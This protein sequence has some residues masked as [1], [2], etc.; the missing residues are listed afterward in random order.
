MPLYFYLVTIAASL[1]GLTIAYYIDA[2][3]R[4]G[5][6]MVCP[7]D[8]DCEAVVTSKYSTFLG[9]PL[10]KW[11]ML[12]YSA[13]IVVYLIFIFYPSLAHPAILGLVGISSAFASIFSLYLT[14]IQF[15]RLHEWCAWCLASALASVTIFLAFL[16]N[17]FLV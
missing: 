12:Y 15:A 4:S 16:G 6:K 10:E 8:S 11:G 7:L 14:Y 2:H 3:K 5:Q 9:H 1:V 17:L 13:I